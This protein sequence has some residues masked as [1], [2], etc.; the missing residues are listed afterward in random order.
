MTET[1]SEITEAQ[2]APLVVKRLDAGNGVTSQ[3]WD[4]FVFA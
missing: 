3:R 2:R 1:G 4:A